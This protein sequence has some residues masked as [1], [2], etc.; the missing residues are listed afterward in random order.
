MTPHV[1]E[2]WKPRLRQFLRERRGEDRESPSTV[3]F[4]CGQSVFIRFPDGSHALFRYAF[5]IVDE[6]AGEVAVFTEH[7]GYHVFPA[8]EAEVEILQS[9]WPEADASPRD[10]ADSDDAP[11]L[12]QLW[13]SGVHSPARPA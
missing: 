3:D 13:S 12:S 8:G 5:A 7:C 9:V 4:P 1:P 10:A 11:R 2:A 6:T